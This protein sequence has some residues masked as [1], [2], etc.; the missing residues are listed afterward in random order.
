MAARVRY[1]RGAIHHPLQVLFPDRKIHG[2]DAVQGQ[3]TRHR[4]LDICAEKDYWLAPA[5]FRKPHMCKIHKRDGGYEML[6]CG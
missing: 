3:A 5:H 6:W 2:Y 4:L 1:W